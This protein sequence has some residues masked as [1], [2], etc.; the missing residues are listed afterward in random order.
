MN[1]IQDYIINKPFKVSQAQ[2]AA[3]LDG[4]KNERVIAGAGAGKTEILIR[5]VIYLL[6]IKKLKPENIVAFT[7][8]DKAA[9]EMKERIIRRIREID[10]EYNINQLSHIYIGTIHSFCFRVLQESYG[11]GLYKL[12]DPNEEMAYILSKYY[13]LG[14]SK[15]MGTGKIN[16]CITFQKSLGIYYNELIDKKAL[17]KKNPHFVKVINRYKDELKADKILTFDMLAP[18]LIREVAH[19]GNFVENV[20]YLLV[21]EYQDINKAQFELIRLIGKSAG[22]FAVGDPRQS[23]YQWRGSNFKYFDDFEVY[24]TPEQS[25]SIDQNR[26]SAP[27]IVKI[28]NDIASCFTG[29]YYNNMLPVRENQGMV[30]NT[31]YKNEEEEAEAICSTILEQVSNHSKKYSDFSIL[32]RSVKT[33]G[34]PIIKTLREQGVPYIVNGTFGLF[35]RAE[36]KALGMIFAYFSTNGFWGF[37]SN[38]IPRERLL[39][40]AFELWNNNIISIDKDNAKN[41]LNNI[42]SNIDKYKDYKQIYADVLEA[43]DYKKL[44]SGNPDLEVLFYNIGRFTQ[45]LGDFEKSM[46]YR[47]NKRNYEAEM[48]DLCWYMNIYASGAYTEAKIENNSDINAVTISTIHQA[49]GLEWPVVFLPSIIGRRFPSLGHGAE[50]LSVDRSLYDYENYRTNLDSEYRLFYVAV[51]RA[52]DNCLISSFSY[53]AKGT[54]TSISTFNDIVDGLPEFNNSTQLEIDTVDD[55]EL[56][57]SKNVTDLVDYLRCPHHYQLSVE[58][59]YTQGVSQFMGYGETI[60]FILQKISESMKSGKTLKEEDI[61][62]I[63]DSEFYLRFAPSHLIDKLKVTVASQIVNIFSTYLKDRN[64]NMIESRLELYD[65]KSIIEGRVDVVMDS[66]NALEVIDYKTSDKIITKEQAEMQVCLYAA[67]LKSLGYNVAKGTILSITDGNILPVDVS[68]DNLNRNIKK[69]EKIVGNIMD[70]KFAGK[71]SK[72]CTECE[73][74]TICKYYYS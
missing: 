42:Y 10:S 9:N 52:R 16:Q 65:N 4:S 27:L 15:E 74:N 36:A 53:Y 48:N 49:K 57:I 23:I 35:E 29:K 31:V 34:A 7:F 6:L 54:K 21:D 20:K 69:A 2:S 44:D 67:A 18:Y 39:D 58:Y 37:K 73:Y 3:I 1:N 14:I 32:F 51:T 62:K 8:T 70:K 55:R 17:E 30:F 66:S 26:R 28:S 71:I 33:S 60:H 13:A 22:I 46:R 47:G 25:Y 64:I 5:K 72:F 61:K 43:L 40:T 59:G 45:V 19:K 63:I 50:Q 11:Y 38:S 68:I 12:L 41:K 24:F 56:Y